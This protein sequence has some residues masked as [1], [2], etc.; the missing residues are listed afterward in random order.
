MRLSSMADYAVV[1]MCAAA[2]HCGFSRVSAEAL[3][4]ETGLPVRIAE[5]PLDCVA[6]GAGRALEDDAYRQV[7]QSI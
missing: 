7:L 2:R 5:N 6:L 4:Q 1:T 3:A